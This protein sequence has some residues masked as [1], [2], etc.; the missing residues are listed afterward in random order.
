VTDPS[1]DSHRINGSYNEGAQNLVDTIESN[2]DIP[3]H[4]YLEV[5]FNGFKGL[6]ESLGGVDMYFDRPVRDSFTGLNIRKKGCYTLDGVQALAFARSRHLVYSNGVRWIS[7]GSGDLGRITRQQ[8][9]LRHALSKVSKLGLGDVDSLRVLTGVA[10]NNVK[11]DD[12][13]GTGDMIRFGRAFAKVDASKMV[14]H[15][16]TTTPF[17]A[18]NGQDVLKLSSADSRP[19]L[20]IF[21]GKAKATTV[22]SPP[23]TAIS[24]QMVTVD[25][26][27]GTTIPGLAKSG[28]DQLKAAGFNIGSVG[29]SQ[30][31]S[32]TIVTYG[33][34]GEAAAMLVASKISPSPDV[35]K[36]ASLSA[37]HVVVKL[38]GEIGVTGA[39]SAPSTSG[40]P[41]T[42]G[43]GQ[44][45]PT[46][47]A[48]TA[49]PEKALGLNIGDP[50]PG[51]K[52]GA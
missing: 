2:L 27:N 37:G 5:N 47:G 52:C 11:I 4:H 18:P 8:V 49:T 20:D 46:S 6:V 9:F 43:A 21:S 22:T 44:H 26:L 35:K 16:L 51:I 23:T 1:G 40:T 41:T 17:R 34:G 42:A 36:D 13:L 25:V 48:G 29:N 7:D 38:A 12:T 14:V 19:V 32:S 24:P 28:G 39:G 33:K 10:V 30:P 15:R 45:P 3:I 31:V 50:P